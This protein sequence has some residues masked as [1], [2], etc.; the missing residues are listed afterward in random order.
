[1]RLDQFLKASRLILRRA[2][3]QELCA[4]GGVTVNDVTARSSRTVRVGDTISLQ[5]GERSLSVRVTAL[6]AARQSSRREAISFYE[7]LSDARS[8]GSI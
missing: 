1:M 7:I 6:P 8:P 3:A 5:H 2:V 4:A